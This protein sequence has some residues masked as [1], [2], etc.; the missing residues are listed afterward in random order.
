[1]RGAILQLA[2]SWR[3]RRRRHK[4]ALA[5]AK[6]LARDDSAWAELFRRDDWAAPA[7]GHVGR[8]GHCGA[9]IDLTL[10]QCGHC[11]A[12]WRL[13]TR[14]SDLLRQLA[15]YGIAVSLSVAVGYFS[16]AWLRAHFDAVRARGEWV[17]PE[18][19]DTLASFSWVT[20]GVLTMICCTYVIERL[21]PTG[22]WRGRRAHH[23]EGDE[24]RK[25]GART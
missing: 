23:S 5:A 3:D 22:H 19:V 18:M 21:A 8:C 10:V 2:G 6:R 7:A 4:E 24:R 13:N 20:L 14:R 17:N 1:M 15:A 25:P 9:Q 11:G 12:E 16:A